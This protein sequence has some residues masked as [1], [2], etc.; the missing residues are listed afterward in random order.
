VIGPNAARAVRGLLQ[1]RKKKPRFCSAV[2]IANC[3]PEAQ[4]WLRDPAA[5]ELGAR[6]GMEMTLLTGLG[7]WLALQAIAVLWMGWT[8][9]AIKRTRN[10]EPSAAPQH[11][12]T[13]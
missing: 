6:R 11:T 10:N 1:V 7:V 13:I 3:T 9:R 2:I 5:T 8:A 4:I 12:I